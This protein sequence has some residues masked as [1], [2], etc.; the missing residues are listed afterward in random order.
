M[1]NKTRMFN[2]NIQF[3]IDDIDDIV[4]D[5][6]Y[7]D[8]ICINIDNLISLF[9]KMEMYQFLYSPNYSLL[10]VI[11]IRCYELGIKLPI[12][13]NHPQLPIKRPTNIELVKIIYLFGVKSLITRVPINSIV[14]KIFTSWI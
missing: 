2:S 13:I 6:H 9:L 12:V 8:D 10:N 1:S 3:D 14:T 4:L 7:G 5:E 11:K